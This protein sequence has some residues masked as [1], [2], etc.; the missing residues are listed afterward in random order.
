[1]SAITNRRTFLKHIAVSAGVL[2]LPSCS[3]AA[4]K[5]AKAKP[6]FLFILIDDMGWNDIGCYGSKFHETPNIDKL[7]ASGM[8]FTDAYAAHPVCSPTRASIM[9]GKNPARLK[10]TD[11]IGAGKHKRQLISADYKHQMA[12]EETTI[13]EALKD[14]GYSTGFIGKWHLGETEEFYPQHQGFDLNIAGHKAG[15]PGSYFYP[16]KNNRG[17]NSVPDLDEGQ[18]GEYLTDRLTDESIKFLKA[19]KDKPFLLYLS[20]YAVHTPLMSKEELTNKYKKKLEEQVAP[21]SSPIDEHGWGKTRTAQDNPVYAGMVQSVD[22][23][24]GRLTQTLKELDLED[25]TIIIFMSDNGGLTTLPNNPGPTSVLP[26][27]AGKGWC[28]EGGIREPMIIRWPKVVKPGAT[29]STP[30]ISMDFYPTM[31]EMAGLPLMP[32][33]HI[34]GKSIVPLLKQSGNI[35]R[36]A[37]YWHYPHYHGSGHR[38]SSAIRMDNYKLIHFYEDDHVELYNLKDDMG[39]RKDLAKP[40]PDIAKKLKNKLQG[41]LKSVNANFPAKNPDY[42]D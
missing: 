29:C 30:V 10:I 20:H 9:T 32:K 24:I 8:R 42:K 15:S 5:T 14:A 39:E 31:L 22:E 3:L 7:A 40:K 33:Q 17:Y 18:P 41:Y 21:P 37:L 2:A 4:P 16:Y 25:N 35:D 12:L 13:A 28:F 26:L 23:S 1:M 19:N 11:W 27:R 34:D 6:N 38:P 36:E